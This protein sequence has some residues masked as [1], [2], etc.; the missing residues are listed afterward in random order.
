[1]T[2]SANQK[3]QCGKQQLHIK[4]NTKDASYHLVGKVIS[5][6]SNDRIL[7][8]GYYLKLRSVR[9]ALT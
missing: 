6:D 2:E 9:A 5:G 4:E 7:T 3:W 8:K 1:M